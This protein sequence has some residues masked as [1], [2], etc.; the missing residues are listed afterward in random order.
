MRPSWSC[1]A[2]LLDAHTTA[3]LDDVLDDETAVR[4]PA[5]TMVRAV[6]RYLAEREQPH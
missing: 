5:E 2:K 6:E 3:E 4:T 1:R